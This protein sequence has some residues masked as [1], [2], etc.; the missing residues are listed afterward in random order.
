[1]PP[2]KVAGKHCYNIAPLTGPFGARITGLDFTRSAGLS[3]FRSIE[4]ALLEHQLLVFRDLG[5]DERQQIMFS[6]YFGEVQT[7]VLHQYHGVDPR[8]YMV[9]N[10]DRHGKPTGEHPDPASLHWHSDCSW[11]ERPA[12]VT[13]L[14]ALHI[15]SEGGDTLFADT[16]TAYDEL[17]S[18]TRTRLS[19]MTAVHDMNDSRRRSGARIQLT[20]EQRAAAPP[21]EHPIVRRH[22]IT[23]RPALFLGNH[24]AYA[25]G[26]PEAEGRELVAELNEHATAPHLIYRHRWRRRDLVMIDNRCVL[27]CTTPFDTAHE[28]RVIRRTTVLESAVADEDEMIEPMAAA[29]D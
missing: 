20:D 26:M 25:S 7:H 14:Y 19:E 17:D 18:P 16:Y 5:L 6:E 1:M 3:L 12:Y 22:P 11:S 4:A 13:M 28:A 8:I 23:G 2:V 29:G 10:L 9:S 21:V 15:P 24:A 27:H